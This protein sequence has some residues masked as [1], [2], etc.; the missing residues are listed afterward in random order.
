MRNFLRV[1]V[2]TAATFAAGMVGAQTYPERPVNLVVPFA[3][4]GPSD[5]IARLVGQSMSGTLGQQLVIESGAVPAVR[6]ARR[7]W[8][9][10]IRMAIRC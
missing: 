6:L 2:S 8:L 1:L 9:V 5:A 3:A 7:A 4:G 10:P